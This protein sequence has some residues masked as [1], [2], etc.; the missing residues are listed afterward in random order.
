MADLVV[1]YWRRSNLFI[2]VVQ[3]TSA[4]KN[5]LIAFIFHFLR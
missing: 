2:I 1:N 5:Q 4:I 3:L